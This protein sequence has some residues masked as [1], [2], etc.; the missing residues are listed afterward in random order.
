MKSIFI[1]EHLEPELWPWCIIEYKH[2]SKIV[3]PNNLW[4]TNIKKKDQRKLEGYGKVILESVKDL[5]LEDSCVLDP[6][7][8]N[9]LTPRKSKEFQH[10]IFGGILGDYPPKKRTQEELT[11]F[12]EGTQAFNIGKEQMSTDNAV[13]VTKQIIEGKNLA[14][15]KF[16]DELE[17]DINDIESTILPYRYTLVDGKP[18]IS[19][20]LVNFLKK[21]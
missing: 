19:P 7:S 2:I 15:L 1:I 11:P 8:P 13:Y 16:Q 9:L 3:G 20:E 12:L 21:Q 6:E 17:I 18:L 5:K 10:F 14:D 4:F